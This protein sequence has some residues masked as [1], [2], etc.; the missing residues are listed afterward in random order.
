MNPFP[1]HISAA[2]VMLSDAALCFAANDSTQAAESLAVA[3]R[4]LCVCVRELAARNVSPAAAMGL[5]AQLRRMA[6]RLDPQQE[7]RAAQ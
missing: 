6:D 1:R 2:A 5:A 3:V 4:D 7:K